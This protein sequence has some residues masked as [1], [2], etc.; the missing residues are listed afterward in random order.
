[1]VS[2]VAIQVA[3]GAYA[4]PVKKIHNIFGSPY[5]GFFFTKFDSF[6]SQ[7]RCSG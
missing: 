2:G 4:P 5:F 7:L 6:D 3:Q 1:M